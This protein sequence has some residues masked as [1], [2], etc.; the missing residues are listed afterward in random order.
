[1]NIWS[2][3]AYCDILLCLRRIVVR[4]MQFIDPIVKK[5]F[6]VFIVFISKSIYFGIV[7]LMLSVCSQL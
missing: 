2:S 1:M 5:M 4:W 7:F 6:R 3:L